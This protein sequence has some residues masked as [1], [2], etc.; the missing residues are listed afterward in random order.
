MNNAINNK[1]ETKT[2]IRMEHDTKSG[3]QHRPD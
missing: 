1:S 3:V 2:T